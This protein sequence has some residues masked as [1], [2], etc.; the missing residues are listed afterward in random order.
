MAIS[1]YSRSPII[2]GGLQFGT[3]H[4]IDI[5]RQAVDE[6]RLA[7]KVRTLHGAERLDT[8]SGQEYGDAQYWWVIAAASH[9]GW[10]LQTPAGTRLV[11]PTDISQVNE[12][13]G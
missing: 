1:R 7:T 12:L 2:K 4:A 10:A 3:S 6:G 9:I 8:I 11:I 5:V 13:V